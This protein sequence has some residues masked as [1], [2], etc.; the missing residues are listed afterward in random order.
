MRCMAAPDW[1]WQSCEPIDRER[2]NGEQHDGDFD[3]REISGF[4]EDPKET[5]M[6]VAPAGGWLTCNRTMRLR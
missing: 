2:L 1:I 4:R 6:V 5:I 3:N